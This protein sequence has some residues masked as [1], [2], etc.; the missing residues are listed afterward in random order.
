MT[1]SWPRACC[2]LALLCQSCAPQERL[3]RPADLV[4]LPSTPANQRIAYGT[5]PLQF[6]DL[7]VPTGKGPFPVVIV[8]H[9]GCWGDLA[10]ASIMA[11]FSSTL[12]SKG[13]ATW[14]L[15]YRRVENAGGGW[16]GTFQDVAAGIDSL[17]TVAKSS[18]L[19]LQRVVA[20]GHSSGGH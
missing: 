5:D 19:D 9:G 8:I 12:T 7:R 17:R 4:G 18:P 15:E 1:S 16:P 14:N 13:V 20:V 3:L 11:N 6:G 2:L 10:D